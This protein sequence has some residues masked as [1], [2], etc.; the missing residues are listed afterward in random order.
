[1]SIAGEL[2]GSED[3]MMGAL[4][5]RWARR[6]SGWLYVQGPGGIV[7]FV[8]ASRV[9]DGG[10]PLNFGSERTH[11][12][13]LGEV[14]VRP[15]LVIATDALRGTGLSGLATGEHDLRAMLADGEVLMAS[16]AARRQ[17]RDELG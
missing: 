7:S 10:H 1:M 14:I 11:K 15:A 17:L 5:G 2:Y 13:V 4:F 9:P 3:Q 16:E 12:F 8:G 6:G